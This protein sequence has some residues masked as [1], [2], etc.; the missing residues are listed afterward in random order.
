MDLTT[1]INLSFGAVILILGI[2]GYFRSKEM[3]ILWI[4]IAFGLFAVTHLLTLLDLQETLKAVLLA[5][6]IVAYAIVALTVALIG[7]RVT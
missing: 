4:G 3:W 2:V 7:F 1:V 6:R 5:I